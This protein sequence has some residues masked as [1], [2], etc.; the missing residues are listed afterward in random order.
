MHV[1]YLDQVDTSRFPSGIKY[2][3]D[4]AHNH[5]LKLGI[6]SSAGTKTCA[7]RAGSLGYETQDAQFY[8]SAGVDYLKYDNCYYDEPWPQSVEGYNARYRRMRD[9]LNATGR[10]IV[11]SI[12]GP[13]DVPGIANLWRTTGKSSDES[14]T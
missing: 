10:P 1:S 12:H 11:Y 14:S 3:A 8:A 5:G 13:T 4:Y 2:L 7:G 9:A 6:Y